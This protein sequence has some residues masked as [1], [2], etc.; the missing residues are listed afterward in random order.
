MRS[1]V[2][3]TQFHK[4]GSSGLIKQ[5]YYLLPECYYNVWTPMWEAGANSFSDPE[6]VRKAGEDAQVLRTL[7]TFN[8]TVKPL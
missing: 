6:A 4:N 1:H 5:V 3:F 7:N 8:Y 2:Y